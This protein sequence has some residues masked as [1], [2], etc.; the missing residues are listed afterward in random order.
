MKRYVGITIFI[1][2]FIS[3]VSIF[4]I[5]IAR[6]YNFTGNEITENGIINVESTPE[7]A[8]I[9]INGE[10]KG[11]S[12]KKI[13]LVSGKYEI[14]LSKEGYIDWKKEIEIEPSI[15]TDIKLTLFP[16]E[17]NLEQLT[18]TEI[19]KVFF[20]TDGSQAIYF[21]S[22]KPNKGIWL[23]KLE[24]SIFEIS[25]PQ[26]QKIAEFDSFPQECFANNNYE[27]EISNDNKKSILTC[28]TENCNNFFI[29]DL[30]N[31]DSKVTNLNNQIGFNPENINFSF[32]NAN[33]LIKD[34][35][36][37][38]NYNISNKQLTLISRKNNDYLPSITPINE[39]FLL[40][41][42]SYDNKGYTLQKIT[43]DLQ[44][45][46]IDLPEDI[47][48]DKSSE[49][50]SSINNSDLFVLSTTQGAYII[51]I[52]KIDSF[53]Q[54][55]QSPI[56]TIQWSNDGESFLFKEKE[57]LFSAII[58][59]DIEDNI[60]I[61]LYTIIENYDSSTTTIS[62]TTNSQHLITYN[63]DNKNLNITDSDGLNQRLLFDS[64]LAY[65]DAF[66][67]S[68]N[69][70]FLLLLIQDDNNYSNLYSIKLKI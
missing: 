36:I 69:E 34:E 11:T 46:K 5:F 25:S 50:Y 21:V 67:L 12:P 66:K 28:K 16:E 65:P 33:F 6:G 44:K 7:D 55:S 17:L 61:N 1:I 22:Q 41:E 60:R 2:L 63:I 52:N 56:N 43:S 23:N 68:E 15:V 59:T 26:A 20:S 37:I 31:A 8:K 38:A 19:D 32:N 64:E 4:A 40:I 51:N 48:F 62:W 53:K 9:Y 70:T 57:N 27:L 30:E 13:E 35:E 54:F 42:K 45:T 39:S 47:N 10:E 3:I 29:I 49:V 14:R 18:F 58:K 24:K